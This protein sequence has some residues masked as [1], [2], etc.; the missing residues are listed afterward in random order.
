MHQFTDE[1]Y[2]IIKKVLLSDVVKL[3]MGGRRMGPD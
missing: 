3:A 2:Q 1:E